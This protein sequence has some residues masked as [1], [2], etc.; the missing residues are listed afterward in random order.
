MR[1][2]H[3]Q[4]PD[5]GTGKWRLV[6][7]DGMV[8]AILAGIVILLY[9]RLPRHGDIWWPDA[10]RHAL[11]GAFVYDYFRAMPLHHSM[12]FAV[13]YYRQW[14]AL[15][16]GFYPPLFY[17]A[18][19]ASY[20][21]L[22]VSEAAAL[23]PELIFLF[24]LAWGAYRLS[25][26]WL[27]AAPALAVSLL[28]IGGPELCFWG[29]QIM[30][31]VPSYAFLIW[32]VELHLRYLKGGSNRTLYAAVVCAVL[33][34]YTKYNAAFII[35]VMVVAL[36][37]A[38]GWRTLLNRTVLSAGALGIALMLPLAT[39][40]FMYSSYDL[41]QAA[42]VGGSNESR[43]SL[44]ELTYYARTM[45]EVVSWPAL[46]LAT[47]YFIVL[48]FFPRLRL[49][50]DDAAFMIAWVV[51][52]YIFYSLIA[53]KEPRHILFITYPIALT[54]VV[55]LDR[56]LARF[57]CRSFVPLILALGVL[58][59]SI[60]TRPAPYVTGMRQAAEDVARLAPQ[61]TNIAFWGR[62]DGTFIYAMRAYTDRQDLG[63]IRLDKL[64]LGGVVVSLERGFTQRDLDAQQI[65]KLLQ[66]MHVQYVVMQTHYRDDIGVIHRLGES[67]Q[68]DKF[69]EVERIPMTADY[70]FS[71]LTELVIYRAVASVPKGRITPP[72][73][74]DIINKK[75]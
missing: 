20:T 66:S 56:A 70:P 44:R 3:S 31:D 27:N 49:P 25:R 33:A 51:L 40:F 36:L 1:I 72:I 45:G 19:A 62:F 17:I 26:H 59:F 6:I 63:V 18:I 68:S 50:K 14:P 4:Q 15:T 73:N 69:I 64:L 48:P 52:G 57:E 37:C 21:V 74:I 55:L 38:R 29:R 34:I 41:I 13:N 8:A 9:L 10:S 12:E 30:L 65:A 43:W 61:E 2:R 28:L 11:N 23:V 58:I 47:T 53:V 60:A 75:F 7:N 42:A 35:V 46:A 5:S 67:L 24:V 39:L 22:G 32:A 54:A 16:I 71:F